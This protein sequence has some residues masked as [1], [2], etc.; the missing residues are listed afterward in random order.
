[1]EMEGMLSLEEMESLREIIFLW[2]K[3]ASE[4]ASGL[5]SAGESC[6]TRVVE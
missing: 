1:M 6:S 4:S 5:E 2:K 3:E